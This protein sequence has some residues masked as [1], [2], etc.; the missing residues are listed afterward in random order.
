MSGYLVPAEI[1]F[2]HNVGVTIADIEKRIKALSS[3][4][5]IPIKIG[6]GRGSSSITD[7]SKPFTKVNT[8][9]KRLRTTINDIESEVGKL[10]FQAALTAKRFLAFAGVS[11][12]FFGIAASLK[13]GFTA[14]VAYEKQFAKIS[15]VTGV[16]LRNLT[17]LDREITR[18]STTLGVG[19]DSI[20]EIALTLA[21]AGLSAKETTK[22]LDILSK[23]Q[24]SATF[25]D[26]KNTTEGAIAIM[27]QFKTGA[28]D[29]AGQLSAVNTIS[30]KFAVESEDLV[31]VIRKSGGA[32]RATGGD[33]N[34]LLAL[35]TSVRATTRESAESISTGLRTIFTRLQRNRTVNFLSELGVDLRD[36]KGEFIG[37]YP[38]IEK[39]STAL[40]DISGTDPRFNQIIEELGGFR[41]VSKVIPLLKEF[42]LSQKAL[43][44]ARRSGNSVD[45][46]AVIAQKT[47]ANQFV[48]VREE[49]LALTRNYY[50]DSGI[51]SMIT[52]TLNLASA[53]IKVADAIRPLV[54]LIGTIGAISLVQ[55]VQPFIQGVKAQNS[56]PIV[57][58][59]RG[60]STGGPVPGVGS[61]DTVPAVLEPGEFVIRKSAAK[62]LGP[63]ALHKMNR[64][65]G[66]GLVRNALDFSNFSSV[67]Y[68]KPIIYSKKELEATKYFSHRGDRR[69]NNKL[70]GTYDESVGGPY[71]AKKNN[72]VQN[73]I[74][75]LISRSKLAKNVTGYRGLSMAAIED[76][77]NQIGVELHEP[78]AIGRVFTDKAF[79]SITTSRKTAGTFGIDR[80]Q[81]NLKK[82]AKAADL[83]SRK[84]SRYDEQELLLP[85]DSKF[86]IIS[87]DGPHVVVQKLAKGGLLKYIRT[88]RA[89]SKEQGLGSLFGGPSLGERFRDLS[90][91]G[92]I[93]RG[94]Q[95]FIGDG[96]KFG[97]QL[98]DLFSKGGFS[99][100]LGI[101]TTPGN[102]N[103]RLLPSRK[104]FKN[105]FL[106]FQ[107]SL[108]ISRKNPFMGDPDYISGSTIYPPV[109]SEL[110]SS[111]Q[112]VRNQLKKFGKKQRADRDAKREKF[113]LLS[114]SA[115]DLSS[116]DDKDVEATLLG[117]HLNRLRTPKGEYIGN[118]PG[119]RYASG[120]GVG[121]HG[122]SDTVPALLTPGE[123]VINK[124]SAQAFGY[125]NLNK[126]NKYATGGRVAAGAG[127]A[128]IGAQIGSQII[129][130][131]GQG[132]NDQI[133]GFLNSLTLAGG[134]LLAFTYGIKRDTDSFGEQ[135]SLLSDKISTNNK[136]LE[137]MDKEFSGRLKNKKAENI[138]LN[139][140][141][142]NRASQLAGP[143]MAAVQTPAAKRAEQQL[144]VQRASQRKEIQNA[145]TR[146]KDERKAI[147]DNN[148]AAE[149]AIKLNQATEQANI[150]FNKLADITSVVSTGLIL[151]GSLIQDANQRLAV[152]GEKNGALGIGTVTE[153][154][155]GGGLSGAGTGAASGLAVGAVAGT[156][157]GGP[158]GTVIGGKIGAVAGGIIGGAVGGELARQTANDTLQN[159]Q[160]KK[161]FEE[162]ERTL[163]NLQAGRTTAK[164]ASFTVNQSSGKINEQFFKLSGEQFNTFR[165]AVENS[166]TG[167]ETVFNENLK[168]ATSVKDFTDKNKEL[169]TVLTRFG[170]VSLPEL[171]KRIEDE[172]KARGKAIKAEE[173][174][175]NTVLENA[176]RLEAT[177]SIN[178]ALNSAETSVHRF[179]TQLDKVAQFIT[180][181]FSDKSNLNLGGLSDIAGTNPAELR[182]QANQA[183]GF[184]GGPAQG[185]AN[186]IGQASEVSRRLPSILNDLVLR[187]QLDGDDLLDELKT[188]LG[189]GFS[190]G[191]ILEAVKKEIGNTG[192]TTKFLQ[193]FREDPIGITKNIQGALQPLAQ[194]LADAAPRITQQFD[195]F[196]DGL[197]AARE[198]FLSS[199]SGLTKAVDIVQSGREFNLAS[200]GR[201]L[202]FAESLGFDKQRQNLVTGGRG[203]A[204]IQG[205]LKNAQD[206]IIGL[207]F[208]RQNANSAD[209]VKKLTQAI[210]DNI[211]EVQVS[212]RAL[213]FLADINNRLATVEK[214]R[215]R[216]QQIREAKTNLAEG[217]AFGDPSAKQEVVKGLIGVK[218]ILQNL[219]EGNS[220]LGGLNNELKQSSLNILKQFGEADIFQGQTGNEII[221][222][223]LG[224]EGFNVGPGQQENDA[225]AQ[226]NQIIEQAQAAQEAL[227]T[228][229]K[230][231]NQVFLDGLGQ[232]FDAFFSNL[233]KFFKE[234][235]AQRDK[236]VND[237]IDARKGG[238]DKQIG[239][240]NNAKVKVGLGANDPLDLINKNA[241]IAIKIKENRDKIAEANKAQLE[242]GL[243]TKKDTIPDVTGLIRKALPPGDERNKLEKDI[244]DRQNEKDL[245]GKSFPAKFQNPIIDKLAR[246]G[247]EK[248]TESKRKENSEL[249]KDIGVDPKIKEQF[250]AGAKEAV[251]I[252]KKA[253]VVEDIPKLKQQQLD[254]EATRR[255][256]GGGVWGARG[257]DTVPAMTTDGKPYMLTP[258]EFILN[259][260]AVAKYGVGMLTQMNSGY[261][262]SGGSV[263][264]AQDVVNRRIAESRK[265]LAKYRY[266]PD[267]EDP[268]RASS[269]KY[270]DRNGTFRRRYDNNGN[271]IPISNNFTPAQRVE[272]AKR[273][274]S[275]A[276]VSRGFANS[277]SPVSQGF[278]STGF[279][280]R[281]R[282]LTQAQIEAT[283]RPSPLSRN[284]QVIVP[285]I[286]STNPI[287]DYN[288]AY[289][290]HG[291]T[292]DAY[293][294]DANKRSNGKMF[295]GVGAPIKYGDQIPGRPDIQSPATKTEVNPKLMED[296]VRVVDK[297][298]GTKLELQINGTLNVN[299]NSPG[300]SDEMVNKFRP[301]LV[302]YVD[303][304]IVKAVNK[305]IGDAN[306]GIA[307][308][309]SNKKEEK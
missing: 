200:T 121:G 84:L 177:F 301:V 168:A 221:K 35:F 117:L 141:L 167:L 296:F 57:P 71:D 159:F 83:S 251:E 196:A 39:L 154:T 268:D 291:T 217:F 17:D 282:P 68:K 270:F 297:L 148:Q 238:I 271:F 240:I 182:R 138:Q 307:P 32:F 279:N 248:F 60:F 276:Y 152:R 20:S 147:L 245:F 233:E 204:S 206:N 153:A 150:K 219:Q 129:D 290:N 1:T 262:A 280:G 164:G 41:Q 300:L 109:N 180:G 265:R 116:I 145:I 69:I 241:D 286:Q 288:A 102:I 123:F 179:G 144:I 105:G 88:S 22:A 175:S 73:T 9:L 5:N 37:I 231:N 128:L 170:G 44:A 34:Q 205:D 287:S 213:D 285:Q 110:E 191:L 149:S 252:L 302:D 264:D 80:I 24:L 292:K 10:G 293:R 229:L 95:S 114:S 183:A 224:G 126:V 142:A 195:D 284:G 94:F 263:T 157:F 220:P 27:A 82:G 227:N 272:N 247:I 46:D 158:A 81:V 216:Q 236:A 273:A 255:A 59:R 244:F 96:P 62:A 267:K 151:F 211:K 190:S 3:S 199:L 258:G 173:D 113:R 243:L 91:K 253:N 198:S 63:D 58:R 185:V 42:E 106:K 30:A 18:L 49:F 222:K 162:L 76:I 294:R 119:V 78:G 201:P 127:T 139:R 174:F 43:S 207:T 189:K 283:Q 161:S 299:I 202:G 210:S 250:I 295:P 23:T 89:H 86:K 92:G 188:Q 115:L 47:L 79:T 16:S 260:R 163:N 14:A 87:N 194:S 70:R 298:S 112:Y 125:N 228:N 160:T 135:I 136:N 48:R 56:V 107:D 4:V 6:M 64:Y 239:A 13:D 28:A 309:N 215:S 19:S 118:T 100:S 11:G 26:I 181:S 281:N 143:S 186:D 230:D 131:L 61:G 74:D 257:T 111:K 234:E 223:V 261:L 15:Q 103:N 274:K 178:S 101:D 277:K 132:S 66:G 246:E 275:D 192:D 55:S 169:I 2:T 40:K 278:F 50:N 172:V 104:F 122:N 21:Q 197:A 242:I 203:V 166:I 254:I 8:D 12:I 187:K 75:R 77:Q 38:A 165:G 155:I 72:A 33:L 249:A 176:R 29:L 156:F 67:K 45:R 52:L 134:A 99:R 209:E 226:G 54:P 256:G 85:R 146:F 97:D 51:R 31:E 93:K 208:Q 90:S 232:K 218:T 140:G 130:G 269:L 98:K 266:D 137:S 214:E 133:K 120:G 305:L 304:E 7:L 306:L 225:I 308:R 237:E 25:G 184:I 53:M 289:I 124:K 36:A 171:Q 108:G 235:K 303:A 193:K 259:K 212:T 65:A